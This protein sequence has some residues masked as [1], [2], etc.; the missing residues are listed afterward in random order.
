MTLGGPLPD[1]ATPWVSLPRAYRARCSAAGGANVLQITPV[2]GARALTASP[3]ATW[4]LHLADANIA[5]G[6]LTD[7][8]RRQAAAYVGR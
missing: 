3:D 6:E 5:L 4:G 2:P 8:V 7:L 1:V